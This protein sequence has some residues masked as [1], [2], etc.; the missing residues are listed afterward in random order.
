MEHCVKKKPE[1]TKDSE[2]SAMGMKGGKQ[3]AGAPG[4]CHPGPTY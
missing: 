2:D 4:I 3:E 1:V